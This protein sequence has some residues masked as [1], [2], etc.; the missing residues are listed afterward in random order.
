MDSHTAD[1]VRFAWTRGMGLRDNAF[2]A[3]DAHAVV[4]D[5]D[6]TGVEFV[7]LFDRSVLR[8]PARLLDPIAGLPASA[9]HDGSA[10]A[11][12]TRALAPDVAYRGTGA[13]RTTVRERLAYRDHYSG[14]GVGRADPAS[15][16]GPGRGTD[17]QVPTISHAHDDAAL[18]LDACPSDDAADVAGV[19]TDADRP[20]T[21]SAAARDEP[22]TP[23]TLVV[24]AQRAALAGYRP[25]HHLLADVRAIT[26]TRLRRSGHAST[27]ATLAIE[28]AL[29]SGLVC[30]A[31]WRNESPAAAALVA[32]LGFTAAGS[33]V[34]ISP[35]P[36]YHR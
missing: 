31:R 14:H 36:E 20:G 18:V 24:D 33:R 16:A 8:G 4:V 23:F 12:L 19:L 28:D 13:L 17:E 11:T 32:R 2:T 15:P 5:D 30:Q 7:E 25:M 34:V 3:R 27:A 1:I 10:L 9:F 29:D 21:P 22:A 35:G 26:A 6:L